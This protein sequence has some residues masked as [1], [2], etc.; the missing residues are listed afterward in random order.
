MAVACA[1][2]IDSDSDDDEPVQ[3]AH[4]RGIRGSASEDSSDSESDAESADLD[5]EELK[6]ASG[7]YDLWYEGQE[8]GEED[9]DI[10]A[11]GFQNPKPY[12]LIN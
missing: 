12:N 6:A 4:L 9:E 2:Q 7:G 3:P 11:N 5:E 8:E 10:G 1:F